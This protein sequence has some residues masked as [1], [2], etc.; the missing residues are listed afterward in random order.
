M[1]TQ[2]TGT[3]TQEKELLQAARGGDETAFA[4]LVEPYQG[5][6]HAHC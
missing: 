1:A 5:E 4:R 2:S 3:A 6:L